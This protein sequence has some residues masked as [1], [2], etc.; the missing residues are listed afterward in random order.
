MN[1][2][3]ATL[4]GLLVGTMAAA[5][6]QPANRPLRD[7]AKALEKSDYDQAIT[8]A[9]QTL[10]K[11]K[12][13]PAAAEALYM[14]GRAYEHRE[15]RTRPQLEANLAAARSSYVAALG[16]RP[17]KELTTYIRASLGKVAFFQDDFQT[18]IGQLRNAYGETRDREMKAACLFY[19]GKSQQRSGQFSEA[20]QAFATLVKNYANTPWAAKAAEVQGAKGFYLQLAVYEKPESIEAAAKLVQQRGLTPVRLKDDQGRLLLRAGPYGSYADAKQ[21]RPRI[22]DAF[23][24]A[25]I[26]P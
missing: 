24:D 13:G 8:L 14:R 2:R 6:C 15:A 4:L 18:A 1:F 7:T 3:R 5:G 25:L 12:T 19:L 26:I 17:T 20:N 16:Q 10:E 23:P 11:V 9:N 21:V 22:T